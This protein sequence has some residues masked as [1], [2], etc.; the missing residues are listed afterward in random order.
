ML[1]VGSG[2][3]VLSLDVMDFMDF[4]DVM[5]MGFK[6]FGA[7]VLMFDGDGR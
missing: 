4:G 3:L 1:V 6:D 5:L 2:D 7:C